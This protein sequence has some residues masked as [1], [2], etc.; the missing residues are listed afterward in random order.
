MSRCRRSTRGATLVEALVAI[1]VL[2]VG[3]A[4]VTNLVTSISEGKRKL[5]FQTSAL[6]LFNRINSELQASTCLVYPGAVGPT[7]L[8]TDPAFLVPVD[9]WVP[10][11]GVNPSPIGAPGTVAFPAGAAHTRTLGDFFNVTPPVRVEYQLRP[12][13][14]GGPNTPVAYDVIVRVREIRRNAAED[15]AD[16]MSAHYIRTWPLRKACMWR[17]TAD[18]RGGYP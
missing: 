5:A 14:A 9:T 3:T 16:V 11:L 17:T 4:A 1:A 2:G 6:E 15:N 18:S 8:S 13:P 10:A 7:A 12:A